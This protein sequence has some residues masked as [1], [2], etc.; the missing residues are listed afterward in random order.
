MTP[1]ILIITNRLD[2]NEP[3]MYQFDRFSLFLKYPFFLII[4]CADLELVEFLKLLFVIMAFFHILVVK[5]R[6][7]KQ[8]KSVLGS[9]IDVLLPIYSPE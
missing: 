1:Y 2:E 5:E 9:V 6:C 3:V 8:N 4:R 7:R